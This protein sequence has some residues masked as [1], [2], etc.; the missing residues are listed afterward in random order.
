MAPLHVDYQD[1]I[2]FDIQRAVASSLQLVCPEDRCHRETSHR[3]RSCH[4]KCFITMCLCWNPSAI[5]MYQ[6]PPTSSNSQ[7]IAN[8]IVCLL[9]LCYL[10]D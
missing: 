9:H 7:L 10:V 2:L 8:D 1:I 5:H 4:P 6:H 3:L